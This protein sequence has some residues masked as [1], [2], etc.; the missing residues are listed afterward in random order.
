MGHRS[1]NV[2]THSLSSPDEIEYRKVRFL[3]VSPFDP[4]SPAEPF[5]AERGE[6]SEHVLIYSSKQPVT[7]HL[8]ECTT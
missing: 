7:C 1:F 6:I 8:A 2:D 5:G 4:F 3:T